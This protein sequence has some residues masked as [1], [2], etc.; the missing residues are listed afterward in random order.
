MRVFA[1]ILLILVYTAFFL[2]IQA[3]P[4][5]DLPNHAV[6]SYA[7]SS[8]IFGHGFEDRFAF[9]VRFAPYVLGDLLLAGI[10]H[11]TSLGLGS[12]VWV[13]L[14]FLSPLLG[15]VYL[16][17]VRGADSGH[18]ALVA[19]WMLYVSTGWFF[20]IGYANFNIGIGVGLL[21]LAG[22]QQLTNGGRG[23]RDAGWGTWIFYS[24]VVVACYWLHLAAFVFAGLFTGTLAVL[25][26]WE[27]RIDWRRFFLVLS[28]LAAMSL[29]HSTLMF[30]MSGWA[31][32]DH[33]V[34]PLYRTWIG[35]VLGCGAVFARYDVQIDALLAIIFLG[36]AGVMFVTAEKSL[37]QI[38]STCLRR[39]LPE[40]ETPDGESAPPRDLLVFALVGFL[41][42]L[43]LP[44]D[45]GQN[46]DIDV[47]AMPYLYV[48]FVIFAGETV[49]ALAKGD[50]AAKLRWPVWTGA[51]VLAVLNFLY[52]QNFLVPANEFAGRVEEALTHIPLGKKVWSVGTHDDIGRV[53]L[54]FDRAL[55]YVVIG[56]GIVP[57]MSSI[58]SGGGQF[59]HFFYLDGWR[60]PNRHWYIDL[61]PIDWN[62]IEEDFDYI[63]AT[64]PVEESRFLLPPMKRIYENEAAVVFEV[65]KK[66]AAQP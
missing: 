36:T 18:S 66:A 59:A 55:P 54:S 19:I 34:V 42:Y 62:L 4:Y 37:W 51:L 2:S 45:L 35:K 13:V 57:G 39:K 40:F 38:L 12:A 22:A 46:G 15:A 21:V 30:G 10:F 17:R 53:Q 52:L 50:P 1:A 28:P 14:C 24:L 5:S 56:N 49:R 6:R 31:F 20:T 16:A 11:F 60:E 41:F 44:R 25:R 9:S 63:V 61:L 29:W 23:S 64:K 27:Q 33:D 58:Y 7:I 3:M 47:R 65:A 48:F 26:L 32:A 43:A 8:L